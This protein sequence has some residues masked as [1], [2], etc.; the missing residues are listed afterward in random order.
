MAQIDLILANAQQHKANPEFIDDTFETLEYTKSR[1]DKML[2]QLTEKK[3]SPAQRQLKI[4]IE[5]ILLKVVEQ[6]CQGLQP[7]PV[8]DCDADLLVQIDT[9]KFSN[10]MYHI[11][12][13]AQQA[14]KDD[15][16]VVITASKVN[17]NGRDYIGVKVTDTGEGMSADF[18]ENRLFKP[19][20]TTKGNAGMGI[21]AYDAKNYIEEINGLITV[22]SETNKGTTFTLSIPIME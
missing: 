1:M 15:G 3:V 12:S 6:R 16:S 19:F 7:L 13:N 17:T 9:E 10:V 22:D 8:V 5:E 14:T 21:G 18:I 11:I 20:D 4:N 2:K